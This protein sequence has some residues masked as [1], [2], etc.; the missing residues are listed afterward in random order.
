M[1]EGELMQGVA[2][3]RVAVQSEVEAQGLEG[4]A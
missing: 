1:E 3:E 2:A 4:R